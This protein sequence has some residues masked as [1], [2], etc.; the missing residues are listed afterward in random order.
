MGGI[1]QIKPQ[2]TWG[3]ERREIKSNDTEPGDKFG[4]E[5]QD[6]KMAVKNNKE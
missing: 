5:E 4:C 3:H 6:K 2:D 1:K